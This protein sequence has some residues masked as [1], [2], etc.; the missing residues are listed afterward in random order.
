MGE[1]KHYFPKIKVA[2]IHF[3]HQGLTKGAEVVI[4]GNTTYLTQKIDSLEIDNKDVTV[5]KKGQ[6]AGIKVCRRVR[7]GDR[8]FIIKNS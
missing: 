7:K 8:V 6:K 5:I 3:S 1:V 2:E 4:E